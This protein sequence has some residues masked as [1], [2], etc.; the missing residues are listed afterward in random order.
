MVLFVTTSDSIGDT[1]P[2]FYPSFYFTLKVVTKV[3]KDTISI[4]SSTRAPNP[5]GSPPAGN[6]HHL[7]A[8][9]HHTTHYTLHNAHWTAHHVQ[10]SRCTHTRC[11]IDATLCVT[12]HTMFYFSVNT[13]HMC[14]W[15]SPNIESNAQHPSEFHRCISTTV[16][17]HF[18]CRITFN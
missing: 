12:L 9:A 3:T 7:T 10:D 8:V 15:Q 16:Q 14:A 6:S 2:V 18:F 13:S 1:N 5:I 11:I 4:R 17:T